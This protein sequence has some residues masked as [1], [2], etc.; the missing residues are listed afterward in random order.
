MMRMLIDS[1]LFRACLGLFLPLTASAWNSAKVVP[2]AQG[3]LAYPIDA[4]G[5]RIPDFSHAGY[6]GGG[7]PLPEV[8]VRVTLS[9]VDGDDTAQIQAALDAVGAMPLQADGYRGAVLLGAGVYD[10][11]GTLRIR[12]D[13]VVLAGVGDGYDPAVHTILRRTGTSQASVIVAGGG[14]NDQ[15]RSEIAGTRRAITSPRVSV[16][17]RVFTVDDPSPFAVGDTVIVWHPSTQ[18]WLE[19][20]DLGGVTDANFWR[21]GQIDIRYLRTITAI[22]GDTIAIDAPVFAHLDRVLSQSYVYKYNKS[23][24]LRQIGIEDLAIDIVTEGPTAENHCEDA[25][26]FVGA[27]DSWIRDSTMR[28][29]WHAGVQFERSVRCTVERVRAI[30]PHSVV[31]GGRRYNFATYHAQL[32]LFRDCF[33]SQAR[34][35]FVANGTS[36]DSGIVA[37]DSV[38]DQ[39]LTFSEGHRRWS[40]GLLFDGLVATNRI[41]ADVYAFYNRGNYGTGHGWAAGHS[42]IWRSD[43]AGGR[44]RVQQPP[45]AQN[46]AIGSFGQVLGNGPFAGPPGYIEGANTPGL[47]PASL[48]LAQLADRQSAVVAPDLEPPTAPT[49]TAGPL[50]VTALELSW[51]ASTDN[52]GI[53]GY[54]VFA[55]G[56]FLAF[57]S[58]TSYAISGLKAG[59]SYQFVVVAKDRIGNGT[60]SNAVSVEVEGGGPPRA[61]LVFESES[62]ARTAVG[63]SATVTTETFPSPS[64]SQIYASNF[65]F[66]Q[67]GADF[68]PPA[69]EYVQFTL[70]AVP[71]GTY[72]LSM[73]YK[74]HPTNRG[75]L[76]LTVDGVVVGPD[77]NQRSTATFRDFA[78]GVIRVPQDKD[79]LVRLT[80]VGRAS[81]SGTYAITSDTFTLVPD[82]TPPA[83]VS[84]ADLT[85]EATGPDGA[86]ATF[87]TSATDAIDGNRPVTFTPPSGSIFPLGSTLVVATAEDESANVGVSSFYVRVVDTTPPTLNLPADLVLEA[88]SPAGA[89]AS[90]AVSATD[91]VSG[92]V[93]VS[94]DRQ[95]GSVFPFGVTSVAASAQDDFEN[96]A[97]GSFLVTVRDTLPPALTT[98]RASPAVLAVP[99]HAM[100]PVTV[101]VEASD[102]GDAAPRARIVSVSSNQP[103]NGRGDGNTTGDWE[104]TGD[105]GVNLRAE[106]SGA[107]GDRVYTIVIECTDASGNS[108]RAATTVIVPRG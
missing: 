25:I 81:D 49:L 64:N 67:L 103:D 12:H 3:R 51:T 23:G 107:L 39:N 86:V 24:M 28:H 83:I 58:A 37:L 41:G 9:P 60:S 1:L 93:G 98:V 36:N 105:L 63:A 65:Q 13:G 7:V 40:T 50:I 96:V 76:R 84:I 54:E 102:A 17:S 88:T 8:P 5:N 2:D 52:V 10:I 42:V 20:M 33:A 89:P 77:L 72:T 4:Q 70:P 61:T 100:V 6:R 18:E 66:V 34:H 32:I 48:Y 43:A 79:L 85:V 38:L 27:E 53:A 21:P 47:E 11:G 73:R 57:T 62:L 94:L 69:G 56:R 46:Y 35:A 26:R 22:S 80:V 104:I 44:I 90:F 68:N 92:D 15:F 45:T 55:N 16:G 106:R 14:S 91:L 108:S 82:T 31:T 99:N 78:F 29:F 101:F 74:S 59:Q 97:T 87:A 95:P 30:E 19:A 71:A 75:I